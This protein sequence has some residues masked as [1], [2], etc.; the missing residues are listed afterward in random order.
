MSK[1]S[2][3]ASF[4]SDAIFPPI[5]NI[6]SRASSTPATSIPTITEPS[7]KYTHLD[8]S[9]SINQD[10]STQ[11]TTMHCQLPGH[12]ALTFPTYT[13]YAIHYQQTH[14]NRCTSCHKNFPSNHYLSLHIAENHDPFLQIRKERGEKTYACFVEGCDKVCATWQKRRMHAVDKHYF[15][16]TYDFFI[17]NDG[18]DNRTSM[19]RQPPTRHGRHSSSA[20]ERVRQRG[21]PQVPAVS[22]DVSSVIEEPPA[23]PV[24]SESHKTSDTMSSPSS[25]AASI[26]ADP[27]EDITQSM[28]AL[29]FV[30]RSV[31]FG[32]G[33]KRGGFAKR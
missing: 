31:R 19:L 22:G 7:S 20:P 12:P 29:N 14:V 11:S 5:D 1:R 26:T 4:S 27:M 13:D 17:V 24:L 3:E 16:K 9:P 32:R 2:R 23:S 15:P 21:G 6:L 10:P 8:E 30:P 28:F 25:K 18:I 33:G